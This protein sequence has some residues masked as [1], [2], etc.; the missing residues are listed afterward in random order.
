MQFVGLTLQGWLRGLRMG[1][2]RKCRVKQQIKW[3][4]YE[5]VTIHN[6]LK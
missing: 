2:M 4:N 1:S 6:Q 3:T 5:L